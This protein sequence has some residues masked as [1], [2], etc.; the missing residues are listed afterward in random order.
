MEDRLSLDDGIADYLELDNDVYYPTIGRLLTHTSGY[1]SYYFEEPML[2]NKFS[3]TMTND[4]CGISKE[5]FFNRVEAIHLEDRDYPFRYSSFEI[6]VLGL[7]LEKICGGNYTD[8]LNVF[9]QNELKLN[10]SMAA[11]QNGNLSGHWKWKGDDAYIPVGS[12]I[13]NI[14]DMARYLRICLESSGYIENSFAAVKTVS[15]NDPTYERYGIRVDAVG[16][17][18]MRDEEN[19]YV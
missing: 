14:Q 18:W 13:S 5:F 19:G 2:A 10:N 16:M 8:I 9:L 7:V 11:K 1:E 6:S 15:A 3:H 17:T 12:V 4:F